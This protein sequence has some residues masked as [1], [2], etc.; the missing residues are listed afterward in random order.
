MLPALLSPTTPP[1]A[2]LHVAQLEATLPL[3]NGIATGELRCRS[4]A[5]D[6]SNLCS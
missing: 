2:F 4:V 5:M 6:L 1:P 3:H